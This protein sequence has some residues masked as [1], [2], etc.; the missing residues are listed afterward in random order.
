MICF[1]G[2]EDKNIRFGVVIS[3]IRQIKIDDNHQIKKNI[4]QLNVHGEVDAFDV[5]AEQKEFFFFHHRH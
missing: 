5:V 3:Q 2:I 1:F 4:C